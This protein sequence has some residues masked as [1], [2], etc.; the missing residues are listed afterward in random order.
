V[1]EPLQVPLPDLETWGLRVAKIVVR[2]AVDGVQPTMAL[3]KT[4]VEGVTIYLDETKRGTTPTLLAKG[5]EP[6]YHD[7]RLEKEGYATVERRVKVEQGKVLEVQIPMP[8]EDVEVPPPVTDQGSGAEPPPPDPGQGGEPPP[9]EGWEQPATDYPHWGSPIAWIGIGLGAASMIAGGV[10]YGALYLPE[11]TELDNLTK[12][13]NED[14]VITGI[15]QKEYDQR[16]AGVN[17]ML[18]AYMGTAAAGALLAATGA[19]FLFL[20]PPE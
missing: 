7:L 12:Q 13:T 19:A 1:A 4:D 5:L 17:T 6:G 9:D 16:L 11:A 10:I 20:P 2:A 3:I 14:D 15:T 8:R 18:Y